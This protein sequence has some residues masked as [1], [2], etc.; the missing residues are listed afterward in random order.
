MR[1]TSRKDDKS[2][3]EAEPRRAR[4]HARPI[5][6][7]EFFYVVDDN[8][9]EHVEDAIHCYHE[10]HVALPQWVGGRRTPSQILDLGA[11]TGRTAEVFLDAFT[12]SHVVAIDLF[13]TMLGH[14]RRRLARFGN[15][16]TLMEGD[17]MTVDLGRNADLCLSCLAI[18][19]QTDAGKR[20]LFR[21]IAT[22]LRPGGLFLMVDWTRFADRDTQQLSFE[23]AKTY[24]ARELRSKPDIL[25]EWIEHWREKNIPATVE[26]QC[27]WLR[28]AGFDVAECVM[29]YAGLAAIRARRRS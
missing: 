29:R 11:G 9:D 24:A 8:Y 4:G 14:A 17:F 5:A 25:H 1:R 6:R 16:V 19:H 2:H 12:E 23:F 20:A 28:H 10:W 22:A 13:D 18:H 15:R 27:I 26:D 3:H 21:R 7:D